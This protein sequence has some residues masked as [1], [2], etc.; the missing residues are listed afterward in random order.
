MTFNGKTLQTPKLGLA[1]K[2]NELYE[3]QKLKKYPMWNDVRTILLYQLILMRN[4]YYLELYHISRK[5]VLYL[6]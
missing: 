3:A 1:Y 4:F 2:L 5:G 6:L